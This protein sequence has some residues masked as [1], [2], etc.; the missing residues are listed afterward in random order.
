MVGT[1]IFKWLASLGVNL[2]VERLLANPTKKGE[3]LL[4]AVQAAVHG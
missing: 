3:K 4:R 1:E 2:T